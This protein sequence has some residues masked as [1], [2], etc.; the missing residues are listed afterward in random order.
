[1]GCRLVGVDA[2]TKSIIDAGQDS[3]EGYVQ[4]VHDQLISAMAPGSGLDEMNAAFFHQLLEHFSILDSEG[5]E[6]TVELYAWI[7]DL[8]TL[9]ST[10]AV[11]GP[12]NPLQDPNLQRAWR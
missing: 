3:Q 10:N 6:H 12:N 7:R 1:M 4:D 8:F 11:Y 5:S 9:R 2:A